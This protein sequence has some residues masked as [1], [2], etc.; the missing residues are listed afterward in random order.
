MTTYGVV[1]EGFRRKP[2]SQVLAEIEASLITEFG[3]DVVQSPQS[4]L[5]QLNGLFANLVTQQWEFG[6]DVYQSYDPDQAEGTRLDTLA[7]MRILARAGGEDDASF[8]QAITNAGRARND[9]QDLARAILTVPGITYLRIFLNENG[10]TDDNGIPA[11]GI[12]VAVLGGDSERIASEMRRF[13]VPGITTVGN[14]YVTTNIDGYCRTF[15]ILRPILIPVEISVSV[16]TRA[17]ALGCPPVSLLAIRQGLQEALADGPRQLLNGD[18]VDTYRV[19]SI[20]ES[21]YPNVEVVSVVAQ[22]SEDLST[23]QQEVTDTQNA[24]IGFI[25]LATV[26]LEDITITSAS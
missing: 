23:A 3:P 12:S 26:A 16:R 8:R 6:E 15:S 22:R 11:G 2:L 10:E 18:D 17:D 20:I 14:T 4:P 5:G 21:L 24:R 9:I 25:E 13:I 1:P 19:R 7:K